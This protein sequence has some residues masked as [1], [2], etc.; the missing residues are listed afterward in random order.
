[1]ILY[2]NSFAIS[3]N[4][5]FA[6]TNNG[7][8]MSTNNGNSWTSVNTGITNKDITFISYKRK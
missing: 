1:M 5:I 3:G 2:V 4:N 8:F 6:G 7:V